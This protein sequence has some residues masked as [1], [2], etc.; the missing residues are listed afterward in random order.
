[1]GSVSAWVFFL[2]LVRFQFGFFFFFY[3]KRSTY[4]LRLLGETQ[5]GFWV[6]SGPVS[7]DIQS[8]SVSAIFKVRF[9]Y[10]SKVGFGSGLGSLRLGT[11]SGSGFWVQSGPVSLKIPSGLV[12]VTLEVWFP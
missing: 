5:F 1:M 9:H 12:S 4:I 11:G 6:R 8:V 2:S 10:S 3:K 7:L